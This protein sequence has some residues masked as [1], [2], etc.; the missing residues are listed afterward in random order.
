MHAFLFLFHH[1]LVLWHRG[2]QKRNHPPPFEGNNGPTPART[3]AH[4]Y[5]LFSFVAAP[6]VGNLH[7]FTCTGVSA[8]FLTFNWAWPAVCAARPVCWPSNDLWKSYSFYCFRC[9]WSEFYVRRVFSFVFFSVSI[10]SFFR[11]CFFLVPFD[12]LR[13]F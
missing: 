12:V 5:S 4:T 11:F 10:F 8:G 9:G 3:H 1:L 2:R 13:F 7:F 6:D